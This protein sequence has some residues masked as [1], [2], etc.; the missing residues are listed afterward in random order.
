MRWL[1]FVLVI[2]GLLALGSCHVDRPSQHDLSPGVD[3]AGRLSPTL[4]D[5][6]RWESYRDVELG[7]PADWGW[8]SSGQ[9]LGQWCVTDGKHRSPTVGRPGM[10]TLVPCR[11]RATPGEPDPET[12][13]KN[14]GLVVAFQD[15]GGKPARGGDRTVVTYGEVT[16]VVQAPASLRTRIVA[17]IHLMKVDHHGCPAADPVTGHPERRPRPSSVVGLAQV[18]AVSVCKYAVAHDGDRGSPP[19]LLSSSDYRGSSAARIVR[20]IAEAP[21]RGGPDDARECLQTYGDEIIV[22]RVASASGKSE[23]YARYSG[24]DHNGFDD[25][26]AVRRLTRD[27]MQALTAGANGLSSWPGFLDPI[28][29]ARH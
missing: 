8:G 9:L 2:I 26:I 6:W 25:G 17:T 15:A 22:L 29:R 11:P 16:V 19:G 10:S 21:V 27:P 7:V 3:P 14:T 5:G 12:L 20:Q 1:R 23:I 24:C 4:P 28:L 13:V 18:S